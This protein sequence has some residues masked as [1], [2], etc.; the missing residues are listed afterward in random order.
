MNTNAK[1]VIAGLA[2]TVLLAG[3][4]TFLGGDGPL[5]YQEYLDVIEAYNVQIEL[6][7]EQCDTDIRCERDSDGTRILF[8]NIESQSD[9]VKK[10][11]TWV[12]DGPDPKYVK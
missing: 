6:I 12:K 10:L 4:I 8:G 2:A 11:N 7:V 5:T 3:G 1:K 9:V